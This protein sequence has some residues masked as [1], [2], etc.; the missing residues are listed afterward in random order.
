LD[1]RTQH[2]Q[3]GNE[4][5]AAVGTARSS[6]SSPGGSPKLARRPQPDAFDEA[7]EPDGTPRALYAELLEAFAGVDAAALRE[8]LAEHCRERGIL[9]GGEDPYPFRLDPIPRLI[10][11]REWEELER[12]LAQRVRALD[13]F[14][15][16]SYAGQEIVRAGVLPARALESCDRFERRLVGLPPP[17][18]RVGIA[19]LDVVRST[20]GRFYVLEDNVRAPSGVAYLLAAREALD[21]HL[22]E[23]LAGGRVSLEGT[24]EAIGETLRAAAPEGV[25][26]PVAVVLTD[27]PDNSAYYEH[28]RIAEELSIELVTLADLEVS[29][30]RLHVRVDGRPKPVDVVYRRTDEDRL[31]EEN[32]ELTDVGAA[33]FGPIRAGTL[34]CVNAFGSGVADDKLMHAYV[35]GMVRFYLDEEPLLGSVSTYDLAVPEV[36]AEALERIDE[37]VVKPRSGYGGHGVVVAPHAEPGDVRELADEISESPGEYIAQE[38]IMISRHPTATDDGLEPRHVDLRPFVL[39]TPDSAHVV[40]GGV[41]RVALDRDAL[42]VNSSQEGGAKDTWV[43]S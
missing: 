27:G 40:P 16:D 7:H 28:E 35:A 5:L 33:L 26:D 10:D 6:M 43:M 20:D 39:L 21:R 11:A 32:G 8:A 4:M 37:L 36:R 38:T 13:S 18:I 31:D 17:P 25:D 1:I 3:A 41:T 9:F 19:G 23:G 22:P 42:V 29:G 2:R 24:I 15:A 12:G 30:D 34:N 14:I